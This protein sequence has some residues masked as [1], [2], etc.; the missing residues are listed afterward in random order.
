M[1]GGHIDLVREMVDK[2][3]AALDYKDVVCAACV[4]DGI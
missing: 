3:G 1:I 4:H 2:H